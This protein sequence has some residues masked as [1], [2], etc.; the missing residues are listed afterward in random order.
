MELACSFVRYR[1]AHQE[2]CAA[3]LPPSTA[4]VAHELLG[5]A[6]IGNGQV[7]MS[8]EELAAVTRCENVN[9]ARRHLS[10]LSGVGLIHYST[11]DFV[12]V[13][14]LAWLRDGTN[15]VNAE[16]GTN[17]VEVARARA[18]SGA[19]TRR[20]DDVEVM[21]FGEGEGGESRTTRPG[22]GSDMSE[23]LKIDKRGHAL[24]THTRVGL[25]VR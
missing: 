3:A 4:R 14:W 23:E 5:L 9:A 16:D 21:L 8:W 24:V 19:P 18:G 20:A 22:R 12:Y 2:I 1:L 11:N 6:D 15:N 10:R 13:T 7:N 25:L 17:D